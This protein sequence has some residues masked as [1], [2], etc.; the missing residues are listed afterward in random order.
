[1]SIYLYLCPMWTHFATV[2][3]GGLQNIG[4][5]QSGNIIVLS[6]FHRGIVDISTGMITFRDSGDWWEDFKDDVG[7]IPGFGGEEDMSI[8][9]SGLHAKDILEKKTVDGWELHLENALN[10]KVPIR[11]FFIKDAKGEAKI[12]ITD[13]GPCEI[14]TYGFCKEEK[15][16]V[17]ATGCE[18]VI[19]K[20]QKV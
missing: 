9:L 6:S 20:R 13:N 14:M 8:R 16:L 17:V 11:Q 3:I 7:E 10:G 2:P 1:M 19:W 12:F 15:T 4:F 18:L 5:C